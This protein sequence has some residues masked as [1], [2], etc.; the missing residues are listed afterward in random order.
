MDSMGQS[1]S[2]VTSVQHQMN[3]NTAYRNGQNSTFGNGNVASAEQMQI[4]LNAMADYQKAVGQKAFE[5]QL[6]ASY[7]VTK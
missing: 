1:L 3:N 5:S 4:D 6:Y 7:F 2:P